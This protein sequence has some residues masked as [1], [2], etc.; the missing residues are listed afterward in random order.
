[1]YIDVHYIKLLSTGL[2]YPIKEI[3]WKRQTVTYRMSNQYVP[4][5][6]DCIEVPF[7]DVEF[8]LE[9]DQEILNLRLKQF[10]E[11]Y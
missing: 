4:D 2:L 10:L 9:S 5:E 1:M 3:D 8:M 6:S 11:C 7:N